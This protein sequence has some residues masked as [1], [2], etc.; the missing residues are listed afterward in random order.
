MKPLVKNSFFL[1]AIIISIN[2]LSIQNSQAQSPFDKMTNTKVNKILLR[3]AY[4]VEGQLGN[5]QIEYKER[6]LLVITDEDANRV[7]IMTPIVE[8]KK[9]DKDEMRTLLEA[10]FD[11]ALDAKY[12]LFHD[13]VWS[14]YTHPLAELSVEQLKDAMKQVVTLANNYG[15]TYTSTN[16]V[17]GGENN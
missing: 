12:S 13:Y 14:V 8:Q 3:E 4:N 17:F 16:F 1:I 9:M 10:N 6:L 15:T 2:L 5:W 7:R 11:R